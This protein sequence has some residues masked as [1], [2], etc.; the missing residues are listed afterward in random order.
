MRW[1]PGRDS[2]STSSSSR[3]WKEVYAEIDQLEKTETEGVIYVDY[4]EYYPIPLLVG[5]GL[6]VLHLLAVTTRFRTLP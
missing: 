3:T 4:I 1:T 5:L 6:L 2:A